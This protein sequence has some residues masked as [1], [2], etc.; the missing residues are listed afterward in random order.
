M[1]EDLAIAFLVVVF[2]VILAAILL[3]I[4]ARRYYRRLAGTGRRFSQTLSL[5]ELE[6]DRSLHCRGRSLP[7]PYTPECT[8]HKSLPRDTEYYQTVA[9]SPPEYLAIED[10][11]SF[12]VFISNMQKMLSLGTQG[13]DQFLKLLELEPG[14]L[15]QIIQQ[16]QQDNQECHLNSDSS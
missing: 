2:A 8:H 12:V 1:I 5:S 14:Y 3:A 4:T 9:E 7:P 15:L 6:F 16:H 13:G 10:T 11:Q